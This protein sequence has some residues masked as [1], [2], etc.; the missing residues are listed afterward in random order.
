[1]SLY[2][3]TNSSWNKSLTLVHNLELDVFQYPCS[4]SMSVSNVITPELLNEQIVSMS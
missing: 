1:M 4:I 2:I 3:T